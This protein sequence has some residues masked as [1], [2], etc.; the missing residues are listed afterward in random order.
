MHAALDSPGNSDQRPGGADIGRTLGMSAAVETVFRDALS[1]PSGLILIAGPA[2]SGRTT[3]REAG[4]MLRPHALTIGEIEDRATAEGAVQAA[5]AGELVLAAIDAGDAVGA[6]SRF[7][8]MKVETFL[9]ASTLRAVLAQHLVRR[10]CPDC[11]EPIQA[12]ARLTARLGFDPGTIV[13]QSAGCASCDRLGHRGWI[14]LFEAIPVDMAMRRL[15]SGGGDEAVIA[16]H[17]FRDRPNLGGAARAAV[18]DG[19]IAPEDALR[20]S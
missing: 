4:L 1:A 5:L 10:L 13:Y 19:A 6:I 20:L 3:T 12:S 7:R 17:A 2:G 16:G 18:R 11:C 8:A 9:I 14:G 15:I